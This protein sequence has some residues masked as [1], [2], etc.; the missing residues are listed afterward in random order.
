MAKALSPWEATASKAEIAAAEAMTEAVNEH[1]RG[2]GRLG[3]FSIP[4][5]LAEAETPARIVAHRFRAAGWHVAFDAGLEQMF[6][7]DAAPEL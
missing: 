5:L 2:R 1:L 3:P 7:R 4:G 6:F